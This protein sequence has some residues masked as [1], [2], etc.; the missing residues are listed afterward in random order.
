MERDFVER[1]NFEGFQGF[2]ELPEDLRGAGAIELPDGTYIPGSEIDMYSLNG[3]AYRSFVEPIPGALSNPVSFTAVNYLPRANYESFRSQRFIA[4]GVAF[5]PPD[6]TTFVPLLVDIATL[7]PAS[8][9]TA[10]SGVLFVPTGYAGVITGLRQWVGN[11]NL[12]QNPNG[13]PDDVVWRVEAGSTPIFNFGNFPLMMSALDYEAKLFSIVTETTTIQ[14]S[15]KNNASGPF[16]AGTA[17]Q[18]ILTGH[19]F[20]IDELDDIFRNR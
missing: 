9:Q 20:P 10:S 1:E 17:V 11:S 5:L 4:Y 15:V 16:A 2:G 19:W 7:P 3:G 14:L 18:A 6:P 12:V 8:P 13:Q